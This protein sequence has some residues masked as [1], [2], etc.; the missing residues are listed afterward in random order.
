MASYIIVDGISVYCGANTLETLARRHIQK[1]PDDAETVEF[2][3]FAIRRSS[4]INYERFTKINRIL[5]TKCE[6]N[7]LVSTNIPLIIQSLSYDSAGK[8]GMKII[9]TFNYHINLKYL[10]FNNVVFADVDI[11]RRSL[12]KYLRSLEFSNCKLPEMVNLS[13]YNTLTHLSYMSSRMHV[14]PHRIPQSV[15]H[16][17]ICGSIINDV[18]PDLSALK[19][20]VDLNLSYNTFTTLSRHIYRA[21]LPPNIKKIKLFGCNLKNINELFT[22]P[23]MQIVHARDNYN[24]ANVTTYDSLNTIK[25]LSLSA[26]TMLGKP[27]YLSLFYNL[28]DLHIANYDINSDNAKLLPSKLEKLYIRS[29]SAPLHLKH[30]KKLQ[31]CSA[32]HIMLPDLLTFLPNSINELIAPKHTVEEKLIARFTN[33]KIL[34][35]RSTGAAYTLNIESSSIVRLIINKK[36]IK[37]INSLPTTLKKFSI[38]CVHSLYSPQPKPPRFQEFTYIN[39]IPPQIEPDYHK[40]SKIFIMTGV[41]RHLIRHLIFKVLLP[42]YN[43]PE[44]I[45]KL[46]YYAYIMEPQFV[47][48]NEKKYLQMRP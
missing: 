20:L 1:I 3:K 26:G 48:N 41:A 17:I 32:T 4:N 19:N 35:I 12:P 15:K 2:A 44:N 24:L 43:I 45:C 39:H 30:L 13:E 14:I 27:L 28:V 22:M 46:I 37:Y 38:N 21:N 8:C 29:L 10:K 16:L 25:T 11:L 42:K 40:N 6:H 33:L 47:Q 34:N 7:E 36:N 18:F 23:N 9:G 31:I 5:F